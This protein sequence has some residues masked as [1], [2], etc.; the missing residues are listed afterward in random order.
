M[1]NKPH[2]VRKL[3]SNVKS[4]QKALDDLAHEDDFIEMIKHFHQ[5]G[6]TTPAEFLLVSGVIDQFAAQVDALAATKKLLLVGSKAVL[7]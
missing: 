4:I 6:W 5:P 2:D 7:G 1:G 3:E